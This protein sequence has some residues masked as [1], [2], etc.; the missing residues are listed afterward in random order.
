[1]T[2]LLL[3]IKQNVSPIEYIEGDSFISTAFVD[4]I[5]LEGIP[6]R[7]LHTNAFRGLSYCKHLHLA[8]S[9]I[10][11][12]EANAFYRANNINLL[13]LKYSRIKSIHAESFRGIFNVELIDLR[14]N[15]LSKIDE[16]AFGPLISFSLSIEQRSKTI[17]ESIVVVDNEKDK[18]VAR[19]VIFEQNPIQCDC[20]LLWIL[21][22]KSYANHVSLPEICAGPKGYDCMRLAE[23]SMQN[24][25]CEA[26]NKTA[27]PMKGPCEDLKFEADKG[28]D[29][30][31]SLPVH[32]GKVK[33][34]EGGYRWTDESQ[35]ESYD[36]NYEY[37]NYYDENKPAEVTT[38]R[39]TTRSKFW[40]Q[41]QLKP[42][43]Q[44]NDNLISLFRTTPRA[45]E[46]EDEEEELASEAT[47]LEETS[48]LRNQ[49][50]ADRNKSNS[51]VFMSNTSGGSSLNKF[52]YFAILNVVGYFC[53]WQ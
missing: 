41:Q 3:S 6:S 40:N 44:K 10:E 9:F 16:A 51:K 38:M 25:R 47:T 29:D 28:V 42:L 53:L 2:D 15:Y 19:K 12:I 17:N 30:V 27:A 32:K 36:P 21:S 49:E 1:M 13:N 18:F 5:Y 50:H 33:Y 31:Y 35:D 8:Y 43:E 11:H 52:I 48:H 22:R 46:S 14:G 20:H 24:M 26:T 7:V 4:Q 37:E 45:I 39:V 23:L 34:N